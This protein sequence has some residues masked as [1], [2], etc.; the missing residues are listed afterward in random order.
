MDLLIQPNSRGIRFDGYDDDFIQCIFEDANVSGRNERYEFRCRP[1]L[2]C[3]GRV[4]CIPEE[5]AIPLWLMILFTILGL[6]L[7][8]ALLGTVAWVLS[9][10]S[11][12]SDKSKLRKT[13]SQFGYQ[14]YKQRESQD[15]LD[16]ESLVRKKSYRNPLYTATTTT[17]KIRETFD[18]TIDD[19]NVYDRAGTGTDTGTAT[20][21]ETTGRSGMTTAREQQKQLNTAGIRRGNHEAT[22][23]ASFPRTVSTMRGRGRSS[24]GNYSTRETFEERCEENYVVRKQNDANELS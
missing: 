3:C 2:E 17:V 21:G 12:C 8:L 15:G 6:L 22:Q 1:D 10:I 18:R 4:C 20:G 7:L 23:S 24:S 11:K 13:T 5:T 16:T 9:K 14:P 19:S